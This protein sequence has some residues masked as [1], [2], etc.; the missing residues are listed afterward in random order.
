[1][2]E[3]LNI[4]HR[5]LEIGNK[6]LKIGPLLDDTIAEISYFTGCKA[7]G[8]RILDK[9]GNI[10][11]ESYVGFNKKFY[12][13]ESPLSIK[14]DQCMCINEIKGTTN[15]KLPY[16]TK[17]GS[18]YTN[19]STSLLATTSENDKGKMRNTCNEHGY[20]SVAL[21]PIRL[22]DR[23][24]GL[25]H[26]A[27]PRENQIPLK[28]VEVLEE[29]AIVL[30]IAIRRVRA[31]EKLQET[32]ERYRALLHL[33]AEVGESIVMIQDNEQGE[34]IQTF[35]SEQWPRI[36]GYSEE[37]LL[38]MPFLNLISTR[39]RTACI[40]RHRRKMNGEALPGLYEM[41]IISKDGKKVPIELTSAKSTFEKSRANVAF[42]RD[43]SERIIADEER[44]KLAKFPSENPNPVMRVAKDG[45]ILYANKAS[46]SLLNTWGCKKG[47]SLPVYWCNFALDT[48]HTG[49]NKKSEVNIGDHTLSLTFAPMMD[50]DNIHIYALDITERKT[51]EDKL[52]QSE[53]QL[54]LLSQKIINAQEEERTRIARELHD[55]LA[56]ELVVL[57]REAQS[58][59]KNL[60][61]PASHNELDDLI[62]LVDSI[63]DKVHEMSIELRP[64]MLDELGLIRALQWYLKDFDYRTGIHCVFNNH[65]RDLQ[66]DAIGREVATA[67]YRIFQEATLNVHKHSKADNVII[68]VYDRKSKLIIIIKDDGIGF[69]KQTLQ[70]RSSL[71][72]MGMKERASIVG[73]SMKI[74]GNRDH[75]TKITISLPIEELVV[76]QE[77]T[78]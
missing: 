12:G 51:A 64:K 62:S 42:I 46:S 4:L 25:I 41:S 78:R 76:S 67:V 20:E 58:L 28:V 1:M 18:F 74:E 56:Q 15:T 10:P 66:G 75:G 26:L 48:F 44:A 14:S 11:Y 47:Q 39:D 54:R 27:D 8:I 34:A 43:I 55:Q 60:K 69:N 32:E 35:V 52:R 59:N 49:E 68:D 72:L 30:G 73:G 23:I 77:N 40:D 71:G 31:E 24:L 5:I 7:I 3:K 13:L 57:R 6:S 50:S 61:A 16:Y 37:E 38:G 36:T 17:G 19:C 29:T 22:G 21:I 70:D 33:E 9:Q 63:S 2:M 65:C 45:T 53:S